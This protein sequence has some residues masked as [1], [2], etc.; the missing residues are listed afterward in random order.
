MSD[1]TFKKLANA[2]CPWGAGY[3]ATRARIGAV[4]IDRCWEFADGYGRMGMGELR[5]LGLTRD[6]SHV[7]DSS[8]EALA[9]IAG[10]LR[11][12]GVL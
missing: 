10:Y 4:G 8:D 5:R 9:R 2:L 11:R 6:W 3:E 12:S 7:R 1:S